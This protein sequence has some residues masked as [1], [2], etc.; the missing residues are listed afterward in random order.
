MSYAGYRNKHRRKAY[1]RAWGKLRRYSSGG[2][3]MRRTRVV[4]ERMIRKEMREHPWAGRRVAKRIARD[5]RR[6]GINA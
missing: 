2:K 1:L 4:P 5:H 6:L 3:S